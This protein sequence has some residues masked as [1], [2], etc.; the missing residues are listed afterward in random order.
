[1]TEFN[2]YAVGRVVRRIRKSKR[3][4]Q[5]VFSGFAQLARSHLTMIENGSKQAK[6]VILHLRFFTY[7]YAGNSLSDEA[8][9][10]H[11]LQQPSQIEAPPS[12][13]PSKH[14]GYI[15]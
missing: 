9:G 11:Q 12:P 6:F 1:M 14:L 2:N 5:E 4:S 13:D 10:A 3:L 7:Y 15:A 8:Q